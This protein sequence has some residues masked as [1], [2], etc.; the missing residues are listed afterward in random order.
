M[1]G[2]FGGYRRPGAPLGSYALLVGLFNLGFGGFVWW[3]ARARRL[4]ARLAPGD[5]VLLGVATHKASR[6]LTKDK[7]TSVLRAPVVAFVDMGEGN[8]VN[9]EPRGEGL[10]LALGELVTCPFCLD[11]WVAAAFAAGFVVA[12]RPARFVAALFAAVALADALHWADEG[13]RKSAQQG[14]G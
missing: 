9:E 14:E 6:L 3:A 11:Q 2:A 4:P 7:V 13:L 10:R 12:P 8:E 1:G 5:V